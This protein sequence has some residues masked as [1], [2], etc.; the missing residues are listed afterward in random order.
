MDSLFQGTR[1]VFAL[2]A[3]NQTTVQAFQALP[4]RNIDAI[5]KNVAIGAGVIVFCVVVSYA[6]A[7]TGTTA[8]V[9]TAHLIFVASAKSAAVAASASA[10]FSGASAAIV[11]GIETGN[12][13]EALWPA[14]ESGSESF[15]W[16]AIVGAVTGGVSEAW[17][18]HKVEKAVRAQAILKQEA[19]EKSL[20][21]GRRVSLPGQSASY[22]AEEIEKA[23]SV[24]D[25]IV[26]NNMNALDGY[27]HAGQQFQ[28]KNNEGILP[29][30]IQYFEYDVNP[31]TPGVRRDALR[32]IH[33]SDGSWW[34]TN[35]HYN[36][37]IELFLPAT[38]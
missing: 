11:K 12:M 24:T 4:G 25:D 36:S 22:S 23:M 32:L 3:N 21:T 28:F 37:F 31:Y 5:L 29:S 13:D 2:D 33:G 18:L 15:K 17:K 7:G 8:A 19:V 20:D 10:V 35:N 16:G 9:H 38:P 26:K 34:Y 1:Y 27:Y 14:A 6:T 30:G